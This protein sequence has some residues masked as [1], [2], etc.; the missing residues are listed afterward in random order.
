MLFKL[1]SVDVKLVP[2]TRL[3]LITIVTHIPDF[4]RIIFNKS[5]PPTPF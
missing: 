5:V 4:I 2:N 3:F 1:D